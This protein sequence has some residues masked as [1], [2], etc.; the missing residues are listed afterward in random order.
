[1]SVSKSSLIFVSVFSASSHNGSLQVT[2]GNSPCINPPPQSSGLLGCAKASPLPTPG[3]G[4]AWEAQLVFWE[5]ELTHLS[6]PH[7]PLQQAAGAGGPPLLRGTCHLPA[8]PCLASLSYSRAGH[9]PKHMSS[10]PL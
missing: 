2:D 4:G 8:P 5:A 7:S 3:V 9:S 6:C 1:M 10:E